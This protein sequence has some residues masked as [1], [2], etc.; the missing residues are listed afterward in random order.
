MIFIGKP[1]VIVLIC[2]VSLIECSFEH[3]VQLSISQHRKYFPHTVSTYTQ[4]V[5]IDIKTGENTQQ[6]ENIS[7]ELFLIL[8]TSGSMASDHKLIDAKLAIENIINHMNSNDKLHLVEYN[9]QSSIVFEDQN[10]RQFMLNRLKSLYAQG[11][12]NLMSGFHQ[13]KTLLDKYSKRSGVVKRIFVFSDGQITAG[14]IDHNLLLNEVTSMKNTYEI[15]I[16]SFGV[17]LQFDEQL[18]VNIADYGSGDYF[19]IRGSKTMNRVIDIAFKGFQALMGTNAFL[20]IT[21]KHDNARLVD[22][23]AYEYENQMIPIGDMRYNDRMNVLLEMEIKI[24][25]KFFD[26]NEIDYLIVELWMIDVRDQQLKL[27]ST[28]ELRFSLSQN[29]ERLKDLNRFIEY[30]VQLQ[31]IQRKEQEVTRLLKENRKNEALQIKSNLF[32]ELRQI[33]RNLHSINPIDQEQ[34][35]IKQ[36][37]QHQIEIIDR[38]G[39]SWQQ[40]VSEGASDDELA[41]TNYH[42]SKTSAKYRSTYDDL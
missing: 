25:E 26:K 1:L 42:F 20:K 16:C 17:G 13:T 22:V 35:D 2:I 24:T 30:L 36:Y 29:E 8:D 15:T 41:F 33:T 10:D 12:T 40:L 28:D 37:L 23:F 34:I 9:S 6:Q 18:M 4:H 5:N 39:Q 7:Q 11:G 19:F 3:P 31:Q 21:T 27:I 14:V 38:R 32:N